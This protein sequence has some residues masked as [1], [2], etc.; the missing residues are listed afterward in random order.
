MHF[1]FFDWVQPGHVGEDT[2]KNMTLTNFNSK[3][4]PILIIFISNV[5]KILSLGNTSH[6]HGKA[7]PYFFYKFSLHS[8]PSL[9]FLHSLSLT[10]IFL[11]Y[12][13]SQKPSQRGS[14]FL[15]LQ[16][17]QL[18]QLFLFSSSTSASNFFPLQR[19]AKRSFFSLFLQRPSQVFILMRI[20]FFMVNC[21]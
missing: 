1:C 12:I 6:S 17:K 4:Q 11:L 5:G 18:H 10:L 7:V 13:R 14:S 9:F 2:V 21:N 8:H 20:I 19:P 3:P 15:S 16:P